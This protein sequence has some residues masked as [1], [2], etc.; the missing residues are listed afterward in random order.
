[1]PVQQRKHT[2][3]L[4]RNIPMRE[5]PRSGP[6]AQAAYLLSRGLGPFLISMQ[7]KAHR[8][9]QLRTATN[10]DQRRQQSILLFHKS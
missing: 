8:Q 5:L 2:T 9:D 3:G 7:E 6:H 4:T 1:M 10:A